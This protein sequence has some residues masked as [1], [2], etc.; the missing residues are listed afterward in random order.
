MGAGQRGGAARHG[1]EGYGYGYGYGYRYGYRYGYEYGYAAVSSGR[2]HGSGN[3][4]F[5]LL[6]RARCCDEKR[7]AVIAQ[8]LLGG[9]S[10]QRLCGGKNNSVESR[11]IVKSRDC[12]PSAQR[13]EAAVPRGSAARGG[14][15]RS[16]L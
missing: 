14:R 8:L 9:D 7:D 6:Q 12:S 15:G 2:V 5:P 13:R 4:F 10:R 16:E 11:L 3:A 1:M